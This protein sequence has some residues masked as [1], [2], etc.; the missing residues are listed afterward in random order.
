MG[1]G[2]SGALIGQFVGYLIARHGAEIESVL[3]GLMG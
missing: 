2:L 1:G 3:H